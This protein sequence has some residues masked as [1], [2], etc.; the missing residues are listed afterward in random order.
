MNSY[1]SIS[2]AYNLTAFNSYAQ[3]KVLQIHMLLNKMF[4]F[5]CFKCLYLEMLCLNDSNVYAPNKFAS[6][7]YA[8]K[9]KT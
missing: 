7:T 9:P 3:M 8:S 4:L 1:A 2:I 6:Q 5:L